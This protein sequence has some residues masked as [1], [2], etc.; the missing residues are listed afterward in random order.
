MRKPLVTSSAKSGIGVLVCDGAVHASRCSPSSAPNS[1]AWP[2]WAS[3]RPADRRAGSAQLCGVVVER[4]V[5]HACRTLW[6]K[7]RRL[8]RRAVQL[9]LDHRKGRLAAGGIVAE[10]QHALCD[11]GTGGSSARLGNVGIVAPVVG[12]TLRRGHRRASESTSASRS[13]GPPA[14]ARSARGTSRSCTR[15]KS[16]SRCGYS[17]SIETMRWKSIVGFGV[18]SAGEW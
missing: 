17:P 18:G 9:E 3:A 11:L 12:T 4:P 13:P 15:P 6:A 10:T 2:V 14:G 16:R 8:Q 1:S 7:L 5:E